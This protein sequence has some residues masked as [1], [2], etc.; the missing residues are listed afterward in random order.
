MRIVRGK[1]LYFLLKKKEFFI[2]VCVYSTCMM[3]VHVLV[4]TSMY[5][6]YKV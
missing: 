5:E 6:L 2:H 1:E 3:Y 4:R